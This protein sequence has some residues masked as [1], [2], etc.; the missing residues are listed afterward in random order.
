MKRYS[1]NDLTNH[2]K[3]KKRAVAINLDIMGVSV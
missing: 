3:S 2:D 1:K